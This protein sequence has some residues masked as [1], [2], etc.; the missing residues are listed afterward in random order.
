MRPG[1]GLHNDCVAPLRYVGSKQWLVP[2]AVKF[3]QGRRPALFLEPFAGGAAVGMT[4]LHRDLV[5]HLAMVEL[6]RRVAAFWRRALSDESFAREVESFNCTLE[7]VTAVVA[8]GSESNYP[9]WILVKGR[10]AFGGVLDN[11]GLK[12]K[13]LA[14]KWC[15]NVTGPALRRIYELRH[16][17]TL[18][19]GDGIRA[20]REYRDDGACASFIDPPYTAE[21]DGG[22]GQH[23]YAEHRLDHAE[24]FDVL[25]QWESP[26]LMSHSDCKEV[27]ALVSRHGLQAQVLRMVGNTGKRSELVIGPDLSEISCSEYSDPQSKPGIPF[28]EDA[29]RHPAT[30]CTSDV[31]L[32]KRGCTTIVHQCQV[33]GLSAGPQDLQHAKNWEEGPNPP[34]GAGPLLP[35]GSP[36]A[37]GR[38]P[39]P[40]VTSLAVHVPADV[41]SVQS[42]KTGTR[43]D[44]MASEKGKKKPRGVFERPPGSGVWWVNY[45]IKGKQ[46]RE[47]VGRKSDAIDLY[48]TRK[49][50]ARR[51]VK[52]PESLRSSKVVTLADLINDMLTHVAKHKDLRNYKS[53]AAIVVEA[54]GSRPAAS[55]KPQELLNWLDNHCATAATFNRYKAFFGLCYRIGE[56]NEKVPSNPARKVR[57]RKE[58]NSRVRFLS[59]EEPNNEYARLHAVISKRFPE[60]LAEFVVS[61]HTGMRLSEQYST[62]WTQVHLKRKAIELSRTKNG[63][64]RTVHLNADALSA[65]ESLRRPGQRS[66]DPVF[67]RDSDK[68]FDTRSWFVP[69]LEAAGIQG[70]TWHSNRHTFCSWLAMA[71][72]STK[73]I[74]EAAG[75]K[76][77]AMAARYAHLSPAHKLSVVER[78]STMTTG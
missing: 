65:I 39:R 32:K 13:D 14:E 6:D 9:L 75:H 8:D 45:Y 22:P 40:G 76:T 19:E 68:Y 60:H 64:K 15:A 56:D 3:V 29:M 43:G 26:W 57:P 54:L 41:R 71:G 62:D 55:I 4:L 38:Y 33:L 53:K 21:A 36:W 48:R 7:N 31:V 16:R 42:D 77:I 59:R 30:I 28:H 50:D 69:C 27:R 74:Q 11:S 18:I 52:L 72:A 20:L 49:T 1:T 58:D 12:K 44:E 51:G 10:C 17:V 70:Y 2:S 61:V 47:K 66:L 23:L 37:R 46:H 73:E 5:G 67:P 24:L 25:S 63:Q 34:C 78:I 35:R